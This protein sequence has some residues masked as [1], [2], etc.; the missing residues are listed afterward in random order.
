MGGCFVLHSRR[1]G[2]TADQHGERGRGSRD[3]GLPAIQA[4]GQTVGIRRTLALRGLAP[5]QAGALPRNLAGP[6]HLKF[7]VRTRLFTFV[8]LRAASNLQAPQD[9]RR[10]RRSTRW[11]DGTLVVDRFRAAARGPDNN[12][13]EQP[14]CERAGQD[15]KLSFL[16][17][18]SCVE[19]E[20][21]YEKRYCE[22]DSS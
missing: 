2:R 11:N 7:D 12:E 18:G 13:S 6:D 10:Q 5:R 1:Y 14:S 9:S 15:A 8:S 16:Y 22:P 3:D 20:L 17:D 19:G 4:P 21:V